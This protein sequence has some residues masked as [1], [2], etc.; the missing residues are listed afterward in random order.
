MDIEIIRFSA[1]EEAWQEADLVSEREHGTQFIRKRP[2]RFVHQ[3][4]SCPHGNY[5]HLRWTLD[6][7]ADLAL[8]MEVYGHF[9]GLGNPDF[10]TDDI[11]A[12]VEAK[13]ELSKLDPLSTILTKQKAA[14]LHA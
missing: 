1:L 6:E 3:D 8:I 12:L 9:C 2:E 13:P 11:L 4:F 7:E 14:L 5:G 10:L